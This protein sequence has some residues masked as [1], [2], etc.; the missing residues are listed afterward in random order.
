[1]PPCSAAR[2]VATAGRWPGRSRRRRSPSWPPRDPAVV[3]R[4]A[5]TG[6]PVRVL[7]PR[8]RPATP[9]AVRGR[10]RSRCR[11][12]GDEAEDDVGLG[13][14]LERCARVRRRRRR[15]FTPAGTLDGTPT[16]DASAKVASSSRDLVPGS[17]TVDHRSTSPVPPRAAGF[18]STWI[19]PI[20]GTVRNRNG[21]RSKRNSLQWSC[22]SR[23]RHGA[24][25]P[26]RAQGMTAVHDFLQVFGHGIPDDHKA[27]MREKFPM[28]RHPVVRIHRRPVG[29]CSTSTG[30]SCPTSRISTPTSRSPSSTGCVAPWTPSSSDRPV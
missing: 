24:P 20:G 2:L 15:I 26:H 14:R 18:P 22:G 11:S 6:T 27:E 29:G 17:A 19:V 9:R 21:L 13:H 3:V 23:S 28:V 1:M 5:S 12:L 8:G 7:A 25:H 4:M 16:A 10:G 30:S